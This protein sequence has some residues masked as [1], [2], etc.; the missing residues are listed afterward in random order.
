MAVRFT[1]SDFNV[2]LQNEGRD[3]NQHFK[4]YKFYFSMQMT[5][6][7]QGDSLV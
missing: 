5:F 7:N 2:V 3:C 4:T 6:L 1:Q